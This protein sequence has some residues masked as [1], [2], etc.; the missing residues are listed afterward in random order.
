MGK[1]KNKYRSESNRWQYWDYSEP[2]KY[3]L[4]IC[5]INRNHIFGWVENNE[6]IFSEY[7]EIVKSEILNIPTYHKRIILDEWI[8]MPNHVHLL[9]E[10][11]DYGFDNGMANDMNDNDMGSD[12]MGAGDTVDEIHEFHLREFHLREFHLP[13]PQRPQPQRPW[14]HI[15]NH[16]PTPDELK[17]YR[18]QRRKMIIPKIMGK[19]KMLTSKQIN[20]LRNTPGRKNWQHDYHD[21]VIRDH[22][23]YIRIK[24][25]I[26]NNPRNWDEDGFNR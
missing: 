11:G 14:W 6:M 22:P 17:Q 23:A 25:Y 12:D 19:M 5:E 24:N 3:F 20:I 21:H 9:I 16:I 2:G 8:V 10:L 4:T 26:I 13:R 15:P 7:G 1:F 18:K